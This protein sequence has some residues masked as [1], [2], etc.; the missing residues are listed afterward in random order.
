MVVLVAA[1]A[2][3]YAGAHFMVAAIVLAAAAYVDATYVMPMFM[4]EPEGDASIGSWDVTFAEEGSP[5]KWAYGA[6]NRIPGQLIMAGHPWSTKSG[7]GSG[8][9]A[10]PVQYTFWTDVVFALLANKHY[11]IDRID[12]EGICFACVER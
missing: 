1:A 12:I 7:G 10:E 3:K 6:T 2:L 9:R 11:Q 4:D 5:M 8:K